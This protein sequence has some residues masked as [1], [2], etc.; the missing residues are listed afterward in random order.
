MEYQ[1]TP[2]TNFSFDVLF[3]R[4]YTFILTFKN[5]DIYIFLKE[6]S[7]VLIFFSVFFSL[8]FL[9]SGIA[10]AFLHER[11]ELELIKTVSTPP[12]EPAP[13]KKKHSKEWQRVLDHLGSNN[14][15]DWRL[16]IL[17]ADIL[18]DDMLDSIGAHGDTIGNK[19][20]SLDEKSFPLIQHAWD[21]HLV[22]NQVAHEGAEFILTDREARRVI[23]LYEAVLRAGLYIQ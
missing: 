9:V 15:N 14:E 17:E 20:K 13:E 19:L 5:S 8:V 16:A 2:A 22:R 3:T 1:I 23:G 7:D 6:T 4:V 12:A 18:L 21:A 11:A 10:I